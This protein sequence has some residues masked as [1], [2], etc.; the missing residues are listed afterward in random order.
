LGCEQTSSEFNRSNDQFQSY[1]DLIAKQIV[2]DQHPSRQTVI[3]WLHS[4]STVAPNALDLSEETKVQVVELTRKTLP[5]VQALQLSDEDVRSH[6]VKILE[7]ADPRSIHSPGIQSYRDLLTFYPQKILLKEFQ[8]GQFSQTISSVQGIID[9]TADSFDGLTAKIIE[10]AAGHKVTLPPSHAGTVVITESNALRTS[11]SQISALTVSAH[12]PDTISALDVINVT[13]QKGFV[14]ESV[15]EHV[16]FCETGPPNTI[17]LD[18]PTGIPLTVACDVEWHGRI[19]SVC[20]YFTRVSKC[21]SL[22]VSGG[23][24]H[25][26]RSTDMETVCECS[27]G[28][29]ENGISTIA[30]AHYDSITFHSNY[31]DYI[32]DHIDRDVTESFPIWAIVVIVIVVAIVCV[33]SYLYFNGLFKKMF[34]N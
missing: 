17:V 12:T 10:T 34:S 27:A 26:V 31:S 7:L 14:N 25:V 33:A 9:V 13:F 5:I 20:S 15:V 24:C 28:A 4:L 6:I 23:E 3:G 21:E 32:S 2:H 19:V 18:C 16:T 1:L 30:I 22:S 29:T 11:D 8:V